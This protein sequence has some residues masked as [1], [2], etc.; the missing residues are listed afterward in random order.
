MDNCIERTVI[1]KMHIDHDESS[2]KRHLIKSL[3]Y[4]NFAILNN[5]CYKQFPLQNLP[6]FFL[7]WKSLT[8]IGQRTAYVKS[9]FNRKRNVLC[10][11]NMSLNIKKRLIAGLIWCIALNGFETCTK[12]KQHNKCWSI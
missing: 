12:S 10:S 9:V 8:D 2:K 5:F 1:I 7:W 4:I 11:D 3:C 6:T